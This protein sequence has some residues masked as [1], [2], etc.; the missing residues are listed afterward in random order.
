MVSDCNFFSHVE[1]LMFSIKMR[2]S[3]GEEH[4]SG[5]ER[6]VPPGAVSSVALAMASRALGHPRGMPENIFLKM[7]NMAA[8]SCRHIIALAPSA[9]PCA[10]S[11][12]GLAIAAALLSGMGV[13]DPRA[14]VAL[15]LSA[16][17][18][19]GA[20]IVD[21]A[22]LRRL[23][24]NAERGVRATL[25]DAAWDE[26]N[27]VVGGKCH[28]QEALVL[29]SKVAHAPGIVG[30]I[31]ISDDPDYVTG[32]VASRSLGY[33]RIQKM[34]EPGSPRGGRIFLFSGPEEMLRDCVA[35]LER[36]P[37]IVHGLQPEP[38]FDKAPAPG[39][40]DFVDR[41]MASLRQ[42]KL[43]R[44]PRAHDRRLV[45]LASSDYLGLGKTA[46]VRLAAA[47]ALA[48]HG[49]ASTGSRLTTGTWPEHE[50]LEN[51]LAV[52]CGS[53]KALLFNSGYAA[54]VGVI[55]AVCGKGDVVFSD[56]LNHA[57][58]IDGCRLSGAD[59]VVYRH[60]DMAELE[61]KAAAYRG[62]HGL[63]VSDALFSMDGDLANMEDINAI[64]GR[65]GFLSMLDEAHA[66]GTIFPNGAVRAD[67]VTGSLSKAAGCH[68]GYARG[69]ARL[70]EYLQN[71]ARTFIFSTA[72]PPFC[73]AAGA[74][75]LKN[76]TA[77]LVGRLQRKKELFCSLLRRNGVPAQSP[78]PIVPIIIGDE[79]KTVLVA[80]KLL[81][82]GILV[83]AIRFPAVPYG[84]AR[85]RA[86]VTL[87]LTDEDLEYA[88]PRIADRIRLLS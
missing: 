58:I 45:S 76:I 48:R 62:R 30:E 82:D 27:P 35:Y 8:R 70:V 16:P 23:D 60:G 29:A 85:L 55:S 3:R 41:K 61:K 74:A 31:C 87:D 80:E 59:I 1:N 28:Y 56:E 54:N 78:G 25:M 22:S 46:A 84:R 43:L 50:E 88:A 40:W 12:E 68:G 65:H 7:E 18:M 64:A 57:S 47:E 53:Q 21:A 75:A 66:F 44:Q 73:A 69:C 51:A 39:K 5:A 32:Y 63:V 49:T 42:K 2:A 67:I 17:P 71:A 20:M 9:R 36:Q 38:G 13:A 15:L 34:K 86:T 81:E 33:V 14:V 26:A 52:F 11:G 77:D 4:I 10:T 72:M 24:E 37:V 6:I 79:E 19:R 83:S